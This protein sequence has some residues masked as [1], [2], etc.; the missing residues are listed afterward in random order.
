MHS[1]RTS[2]RLALGAAVVLLILGSS[3]GGPSMNPSADRARTALE[4][5]LNAW[6]EGEKPGNIEG[7]NPPVQAVDNE[8]TNGRKLESFEILGEQPSE[9]DKRFTVKLTYTAATKVKPEEVLYIVVGVSPIAVFREEDY[10]RTLNMDN[11]PQPKG[12]S[13]RR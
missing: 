5:S 6:R 1:I 13:R 10:A 2:R 4:A 8:W 9:S 12:K 3:C 11:N 7:T